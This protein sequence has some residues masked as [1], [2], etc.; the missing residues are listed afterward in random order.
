MSIDFSVVF[1][2]IVNFSLLSVLLNRF[3]FKPVK[4]FMKA[5][6]ARIDAG[7]RAGEDARAAQ[8]EEAE[9]LRQEAAA[10]F[11]EETELTCAEAARCRQDARARLE[12]AEEDA[13]VRRAAARQAM[14]EERVRLTAALEEKLPM[15]TDAI[16]RKFLTPPKGMLS[17]SGLGSDNEKKSSDLRSNT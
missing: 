9:R 5:R 2:T 11:R 13:A 7:I 16:E 17:V 10:R 1:W 8:Q 12:Q 4:D 14:E 15:L 6:Q 3:L